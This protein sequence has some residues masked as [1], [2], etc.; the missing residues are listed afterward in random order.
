MRGE[1]L[2]KPVSGHSG[3][4]QKGI[5]DPYQFCQTRAIAIGL[6]SHFKPGQDAV[7]GR[8]LEIQVLLVV[9][10]LVT[11]D[12][13]PSYIA[14]FI[15][16]M[17]GDRHS[18]HVP[19]CAT[20]LVRRWTQ[21]QALSSP[22][23]RSTGYLSNFFLLFGVSFFHDVECLCS[24]IILEAQSSRSTRHESLSFYIVR[25]TEYSIGIADMYT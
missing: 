17:V 15:I 12:S 13:Q 7:S 25:R 20:V 16:I 8:W 23:I 9:G 22:R 11:I 2:K 5:I 1:Q 19:G 21:P 10:W 3:T 18:T 4:Y 6:D 14:I 24:K